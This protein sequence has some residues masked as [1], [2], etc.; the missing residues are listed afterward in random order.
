MEKKD[1]GQ[2]LYEMLD[3]CIESM[4]EEISMA[5]IVGVLELLK[6]DYMKDFFDSID[7]DLP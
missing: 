2:T 7:E 3:D 6:T 5:Q 4:L 1:P